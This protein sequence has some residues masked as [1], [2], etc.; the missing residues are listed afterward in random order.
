MLITGLDATLSA[1]AMERWPM[2][3]AAPSN[4]GRSNRYRAPGNA[5]WTLIFMLHLPRCKLRGDLSSL[6]TASFLCSVIFHH[7]SS[8][9]PD[10]VLL[11]HHWSD[12]SRGISAWTG[13]V[14]A[15]TAGLPR[16]Q[17]RDLGV[18]RGFPPM[19][20]KEG[21]SMGRPA[22]WGDGRSAGLALGFPRSQNRDLGHP[23]V[24]RKV[25]AG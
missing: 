18:V 14:A 20:Q 6:P 12:F 19:R 4:T 3:T 17:N 10:T 23:A 1:L 15:G 5:A 21:A 25:T 8:A 22:C 16:S 9:G 11:F 2:A 24:Y 13:G 7:F